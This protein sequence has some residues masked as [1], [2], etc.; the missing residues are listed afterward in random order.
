V[1]PDQQALVEV[2]KHLIESFVP[3]VLLRHGLKAPIKAPDGSWQV[4]T[5]PDAV[6]TI[7][8]E[9]SRY[10]LP[11]FGAILAPKFES[12]LV[13]VDIDGAEAVPKLKDL[14]V[15]STHS[16]WIARTGRG[17]LQCYYLW[18]S[19]N[20]PPQR[21][22]R[23]DGLPVDLLSNGFAVVPPSSTH[24]EPKGGGSYR[25]LMGHSPTDIPQT[26]LD[27]LPDALLEWWSG[28]P[29]K[30]DVPLGGHDREGT[31]R[32]PKGPGAWHLLTET[33]PEGSRNDTLARIAGW[34]RLYHPAHV[35]EALLMVINES[36]CLPPLELRE[37]QTI[38]KSIFK[39]PQPGVNGHP[40]A[41]VPHYVREE[42]ENDRH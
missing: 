14:G 6:A 15:S 33:I 30:Q 21:V 36:R 10:G 19:T 32:A 18:D 13:V 26:E 9:A 1:N 7:I 16:V 17:N 24:R 31:A 41:A 23:A 2:A 20:P 34:L 38:V 40:R 29:D 12:R 39:Y 3:I 28:M 4:M 27:T 11:N 25:W 5:R 22:I 37:V 35:V 8:R 42:L